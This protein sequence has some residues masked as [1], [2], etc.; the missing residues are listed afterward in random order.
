MWYRYFL[1]LALLFLL[2]FSLAPSA[3]STEELR[4]MQKQKAGPHIVPYSCVST[5]SFCDAVGRVNL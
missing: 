2:G 3:E 1:I 4:L 5:V